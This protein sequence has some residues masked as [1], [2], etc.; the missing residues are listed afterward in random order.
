MRPDPL[1]S[2]PAALPRVPFAL[3]L[4]RRPRLR[5][6]LAVALALVVGLLVH[7]TVATADA[8]RA[9]WGPRAP[10][11]VATRDLAPGHVVEAGDVRVV[12]LP[13]A[14]TPPGALRRVPEGRIVRSLV[15]EGE[16]LTRRRVAG[17]DAL[18]VAALLPEGTRAVA[19]PVE[20]GTAPPLRVGQRVDVVAAGIGDDGAAGAAVIAAAVP[21]L[22]V[23]EHAATVAVAKGDL[24]DVV[25][26]LA[27]G[28]VALA[29]VGEVTTVVS[30]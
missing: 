20:P 29:L 10:V 1:R 7:R 19:I 28:A 25:A 21:V 18:G 27:A 30:R 22:A 26:A 12:E 3:T 4:R 17:S 16:T 14:A 5:R 11:A 6:G 8:V 13:P 9:G 2:A 23:D 15:L 24:P